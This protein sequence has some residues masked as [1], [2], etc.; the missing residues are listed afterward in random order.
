MASISVTYKIFLN[1]L[2][3]PQ[4]CEILA[5]KKNHAAT[6][7]KCTVQIFNIIPNTVPQLSQSTQTTILSAVFIFFK[8][9]QFTMIL[10]D[11][12]GIKW[13]NKVV[14]LY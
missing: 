6:T 1:L 8:L 13:V 3:F 7:N 11:A 4:K 5:E 12:S 10:Y 2:S 9:S 14:A